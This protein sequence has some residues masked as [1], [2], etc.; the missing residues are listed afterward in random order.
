MEGGGGMRVRGSRVEEG[1]IRVLWM[2]L[3]EGGGRRKKKPDRVLLTR[4]AHC[5]LKVT[6]Q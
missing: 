6:D 4:P 1:V 3:H 2:V 5:T